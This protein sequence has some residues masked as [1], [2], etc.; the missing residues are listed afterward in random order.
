MV[1][2]RSL[3][4]GALRVL[5]LGAVQGRG[6]F[7]DLMKGIYVSAFEQSS[8]ETNLESIGRGEE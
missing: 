3:G 6:P 2:S 4:L 5:A 8:L 1:L 7:K